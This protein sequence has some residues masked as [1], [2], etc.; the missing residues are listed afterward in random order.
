MKLINFYEIIKCFFSLLT[1]TWKLF[2]CEEINQILNVKNHTMF[3]IKIETILSR[4]I[5][6]V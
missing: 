5:L 1:L 6:K 3:I 2:P 4:D